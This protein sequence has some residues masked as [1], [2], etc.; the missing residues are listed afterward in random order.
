MAAGSA[1]GS[2]AP[3]HL[4]GLVRFDLDGRVAR[5]G[6]FRHLN[7]SWPPAFPKRIRGGGPRSDKS[8]SKRESCC[9]L[10]SRSDAIILLVILKCEKTMRARCTTNPKMSRLTYDS[11]PTTSKL[12]ELI[13][14]EI[15]ALKGNII[16]FLFLYTR[17]L[18]NTNSRS[19]LEFFH[20]LLAMSHT[21]F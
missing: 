20:D 4:Q 13:A 21:L 18:I 1:E 9:R 10:A 17:Q 6:A 3:T 16:S 8:K 11:I 7:Q 14:T 12:E 15:V 5:G 2:V 19:S